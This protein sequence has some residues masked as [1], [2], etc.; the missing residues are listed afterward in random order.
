MRVL[1]S[2]ETV[3]LCQ[4]LGVGM[5]INYFGFINLGGKTLKKLECFKCAP[6]IRAVCESDSL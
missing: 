5:K 6:F 2:K 4:S 3:V 1:I